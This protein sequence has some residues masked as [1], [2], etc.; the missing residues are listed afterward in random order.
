M[1]KNERMPEELKR[2]ISKTM[3]NN[4]NKKGIKASEETKAKMSES[5]LKNSISKM[6][7][8]SYKEISDEGFKHAI[9]DLYV[10]VKGDVI[11]VKEYKEKVYYKLLIPSTTKNGY[12]QVGLCSSGSAIH[13]HTLVMMTYVG[14]RPDGMEIDHIDR[15]KANNRLEN[16][17][18][19]TRKENMA[20]VD[21]PE[22]HRYF[23][24]Y[25]K[26]TETFTRDDGK[27]FKMNIASYY[28]MLRDKDKTAAKRFYN[29]NKVEIEAFLA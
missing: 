23:G 9:D 1:K 3:K 19:V 22:H 6:E 28:L 4:S 14:P 13:I 15:N 17:R 21:K 24:R 18:Y 27:K 12:K 20:N 25:C 5:H 26:A 11:K 2:R 8:T 7:E 16:L 10:S 29:K